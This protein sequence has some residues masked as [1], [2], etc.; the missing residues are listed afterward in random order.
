MNLISLDTVFR[1]GAWKELE[2]IQDPELQE[3]AAAL[4]ELALQSRAPSTIKKYS[5]AFSRWRKWAATKSEIG[6]NL[7]PKPIHIALYLSFLAQ[8]CRS[9][10]PLM[11]A[12][13]ALS[14]VNQ[15]ATVEDTTFHPLMQQVLSGAKRKLA[16]KTTKKE[17]IT[18][19]ILSNLVDKFGNK[20]A[21]L[22]DVRTLTMCL[23]GYAGFFRYD[24]LSK[25]R[26][27]VCIFMRNTWKYLWNRAK[28]TS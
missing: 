12:L 13:S 3:L 20:G 25:L 11:E 24:E 27:F 14:W 15:V 9:S 17:P 23:V 18:P 22:S 8:R 7:P 26:E 1:Q 6:P 16:H 19:E 28:Q 2:D 21:P 10:A 4:P 5:G